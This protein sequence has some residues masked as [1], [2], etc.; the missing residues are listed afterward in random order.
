MPI[1]PMNNLLQAALD[2]GFAVGYFE[3]WD[4][5]SLEAVLEAAEAEQ[6]PV[7]LGFGCV[8]ADQTWLDEGQGVELW[9]A[10]ARHAGERAQVPVSLILNET[11]TYDQALRGIG[12][13]FNCVMIDTSDWPRQQA[14]DSLQQL[15]TRAHAAGVTVEAELGRLPDAIFGGG[16]DHSKAFLTDPHDAAQFVKATGVDFFAPSI[17]N[18][19]IY[20]GGVAEVDLDRLAAI[21]EATQVPLVIHG[22]TSFPPD[23]VAGA[24]ARGA[25]KFNVGTILKVEFFRG[26]R[27]AASAWPAQ[28]NVHDVLGSHKATDIMQ[29]GKVHMMRK[30]RELMQLY[31]STGRAASI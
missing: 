24:I 26:L 17:G 27:E 31:G 29:A 19:H 28:V 13:G 30:V 14:I 15:V 6:S 16:I 10:M 8:M 23:A 4:S 21:Y 22:G 3:A 2:G 25:A 18:V 11:N 1:I 12:A 5:Y 9:G 20:T 7:I